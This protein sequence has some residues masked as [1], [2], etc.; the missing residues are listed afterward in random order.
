LRFELRHTCGGRLPTTNSDHQDHV[1]MGFVCLMNKKCCTLVGFMS[2][3][4]YICLLYVDMPLIVEVMKD[5]LEKGKMRFAA[6][7]QF[8]EE[9]SV[10]LKWPTR[11]LICSI[12]TLRRTQQL[13]HLTKEI[14]EH[15]EDLSQ[16]S[17]K[18]L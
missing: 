11:R 10:R 2:V 1:L 8:C 17:H 9:R 7:T 6:Y 5:V 15:E 18:G 3:S 13:Q 12:L 4:L 16:G 14:A